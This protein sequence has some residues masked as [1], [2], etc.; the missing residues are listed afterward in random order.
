MTDGSERT[1][2]S[3]QAPPAPENRVLP[4]IALSRM[5]TF[6]LNDEEHWQRGAGRGLEKSLL[7]VV[8]RHLELPSCFDIQRRKYNNA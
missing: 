4:T 5:V 8:S 1:V 6:L 7:S 2:G 3:M